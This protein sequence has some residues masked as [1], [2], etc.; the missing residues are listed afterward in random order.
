MFGHD[1]LA[2]TLMLPALNHNERGE[3]VGDRPGVEP[4]WVAIQVTISLN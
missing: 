1:M 4:E 3:I 2:A